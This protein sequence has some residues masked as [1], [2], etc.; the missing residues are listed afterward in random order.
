MRGGQNVH[1]NKGFTLIELMIVI[2]IISVLAAIAIPN[3]NSYTTK[4]KLTEAKSNL[5]QLQTLQEQF[6]QDYRVYA[7]GVAATASAPSS[8]TSTDGVLAW[9]ASTQAK[10][11]DY[12]I[13][14]ANSGQNFTAN[15]AGNAANGLS[16]FQF[17]VNNQN[18]KCWRDSGSAFTLAPDATT[19]PA[20]SK[21]W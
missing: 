6:Y 13:A 8:S 18:V 16:S 11:F 21:S 7:G 2:A 9:N 17:A 12:A 10:Y 1:N 5:L 4:A 15:A 19:C 3:Y 14:T 20:G